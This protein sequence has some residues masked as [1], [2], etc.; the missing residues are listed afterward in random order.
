MERVKNFF[1]TYRGRFN[2]LQDLNQFLLEIKHICKNLKAITPQE[3]DIAEGYLICKNA[4]ESFSNIEIYIKS[5]IQMYESMQVKNYYEVFVKVSPS[6]IDDSLKENRCT[7]IE[8]LFEKYSDKYHHSLPIEPD[9]H[10]IAE[11]YLKNRKNF[12]EISKEI[13]TGEEYA[14]KRVL[15]LN[16]YVVPYVKGDSQQHLLKNVYEALK[17]D[18]LSVHGY[19]VKCKECGCIVKEHITRSTTIISSCPEHGEFRSFIHDL[20]NLEKKH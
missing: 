9:E 18:G 12:Q 4:G 10:T 20:V 19:G 8:K 7:K 6:D 11:L 13:G 1:Y 3:D 14:K 15:G 2:N 16:R 17:E 5:E